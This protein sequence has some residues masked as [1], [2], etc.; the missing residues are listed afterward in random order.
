MGILVWRLQSG[1]GECLSRVNLQTLGK[2]LQIVFYLV[3][4]I[5]EIWFLVTGIQRFTISSIAN[6]I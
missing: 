1:C 6:G 4:F 3:G 2:R 5:K